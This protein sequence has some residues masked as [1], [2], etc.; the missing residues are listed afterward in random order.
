[1][2]GCAVGPGVKVSVSSDSGD[3]AAKIAASSVAALYARAP[4][5]L[6]VNIA[7]AALAIAIMRHA[8][9]SPLRYSL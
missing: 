5:A 3:R 9:A 4:L 1:M 6:A 2:L 8:V 7:V